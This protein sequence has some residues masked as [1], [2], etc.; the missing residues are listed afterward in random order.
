M[1]PM[2]SVRAGDAFPSIDWSSRKIDKSSF[3]GSIEYFD[4]K[5]LCSKNITVITFFSGTCDS[6]CN[7]NFGNLLCID[8]LIKEKTQKIIFLYV[9]P[10]DHDNAYA[11]AKLN[12]AYPISM[13]PDPKNSLGHRFGL[14]TTPN[15]RWRGYLSKSAQVITV[16]SPN[17]PI[18]TDISI[19]PTMGKV[20]SATSVEGLERR[21]LDSSNC[22]LLARSVADAFARFKQPPKVKKEEKE[23]RKEEEPATPPSP[24]EEQMNLLSGYGAYF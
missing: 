10:D 18:V 20:T 12:G 6:S 11:W 21:L 23:E 2:R 16:P 24:D 19:E 5:D 4:P 3:S 17:G 1:L 13:I 22:Q 15:E 14:K 8:R 7:G 9:V